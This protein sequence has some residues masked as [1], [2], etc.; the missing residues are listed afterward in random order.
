MGAGDRVGPRS[1]AAALPPAPPFLRPIP[2]S[3]RPISAFLRRQEPARPNPS[4]PQPPALPLLPFPNSSFPPPSF[5]RPISSFLRRQ[6]WGGVGGSEWAQAIAAQRDRLR[7]RSC[8][9]LL[10]S[11]LRRQELRAEPPLPP[12]H[13]CLRRNDGAGGRDELGR[14]GVRE[15]C[16]E[17]CA[18]AAPSCRTRG[19]RPGGS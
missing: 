4:T 15:G 14:R 18:G 9:R 1:P 19:R 17:R 11:F 7:Q 5:L 2:S 6:E 13:S 8:L 16:V 12:P 3:L 10:T